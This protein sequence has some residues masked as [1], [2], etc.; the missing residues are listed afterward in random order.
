MADGFADDDEDVDGVR[1]DSLRLG[2]PSEKGGGATVVSAGE[3]TKLE[4][5]CGTPCPTVPAAVVAIT[6]GFPIPTTAGTGD[7]LC[8]MFA[9]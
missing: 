7:R 1:V 9:R 5:A 2:R 3:R 8:V 4:L 6:L